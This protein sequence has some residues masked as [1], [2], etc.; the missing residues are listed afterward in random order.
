MGMIHGIEKG[1]WLLLWLW[2][3]LWLME[4]VRIELEDGVGWMSRRH[5]CVF[6]GGGRRVSRGGEITDASGVEFFLVFS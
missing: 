2:L 6:V 5:C 4:Q 3:W 1:G